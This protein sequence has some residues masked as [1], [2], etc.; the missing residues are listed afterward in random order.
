MAFAGRRKDDIRMDEDLAS[1]LQ[2]R[3]DREHRTLSN[4]IVSI[5][6]DD[7]ERKNDDLLIKSIKHQLYSRYMDRP[8]E[9]KALFEII[10]NLQSVRKQNFEM[11]WND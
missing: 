6:Q 3:A 8:E 2:K 5:L 1:Y 11:L 10:D 7:K 9:V 4:M